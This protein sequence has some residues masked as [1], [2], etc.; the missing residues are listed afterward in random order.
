MV[1][2]LDSAFVGFFVDTD[3]GN[4]N[5]DRIGSDTT[6]GMGYTYNAD[7]D[8]EGNVAYGAAPPALGVSFLRGPQAEVNRIDDNRDGR[9]D[10]DGERLRVTSFGTY[11][12][13]GC[14][15]P[16]ACSP[17]NA[18]EYFRM[19]DGIWWNGKPYTMGGTGRE[20]ASERT[21]F[22]YPGDPVVGAYWSEVKLLEDEDVQLGQFDKHF[23][24]AA[25]PFRM[26]PGETEEVVI[27]IV[28]ARGSNHLDSITELR[29]AM[30]HVQDIRDV[31]LT[32]TVASNPPSNQPVLAYAKNAPN[33]F[34]DATTIRYTVP[35]PSAVRL[36]VYDMLGRKVAALVDGL[37]DAGDHEAAFAGH[38]LPSG[39]Y[40]YRLSIGRATVTG[41]MVRQ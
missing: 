37:Q 5:D 33:P 26:E 38:A 9:V 41:R 19:M 7:N 20:F 21:K 14:D 25:G 13:G 27:A 2:S 23:V 8:D 18:V 12:N 6:L 24:V 22:L 1:L 15:P 39:V 17:R 10:E 16:T 29:K 4:F 32:P 30:R 11:Y 35:E 31:L 3:L 40:V 36:V 34:T 28:W